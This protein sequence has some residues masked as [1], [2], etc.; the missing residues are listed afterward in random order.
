LADP[1][2]LYR[3]IRS[4]F[5]KDAEG[6]KMDKERGVAAAILFVIVLWLLTAKELGAK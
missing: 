1:F 6:E 5:Q 4:Q 3:L 2:L